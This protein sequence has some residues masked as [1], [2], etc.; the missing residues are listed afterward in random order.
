MNSKPVLNVHCDGSC[1]HKD[2]RMGM[3][4][5][6]FIGDDKK[7]TFKRVISSGDQTGSSN[8]A[9]YRAVIAALTYLV[10]QLDR[11][12][13]YSEIII[14]GDSELTMR[15]LSFIYKVNKPELKVLHRQAIE[16]TEKIEQKIP[17]HFAW[18]SRENY[19]QRK[20]D[21]LS[22]Q[23]NNYF[24]DKYERTER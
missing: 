1:Y 10:N 2:G 21:V 9:E 11:L 13:I 15:Q 20:V 14:Y 24:K 18:V 4:F 19:R 23:G 12:S 8:E 3:G 5:A 17:L 7:P 22:K 6:G 16:L